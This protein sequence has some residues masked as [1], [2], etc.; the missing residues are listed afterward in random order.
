MVDMFEYIMMIYMR[1]LEVYYTLKYYKSPIVVKHAYAQCLD[2]LT[3]KKTITKEISCGKPWSFK[4]K[5]Y[6]VYIYYKHL[7]TMKDY[8]I[9]YNNSAQ[10]KFPPYDYSIFNKK[11]KPGIIDYYVDNDDYTSLLKEFAGPKQNFYYD[12]HDTKISWIT[13][14]LYKHVPSITKTTT[15]GE[16]KTL[17]PFSMKEV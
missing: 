4:S 3:H 8:A 16:T 5:D 12:L 15:Y 7:P 13:Q 9:V 1:I 6:N 14:T 17:D 2:D 10:I 11:V